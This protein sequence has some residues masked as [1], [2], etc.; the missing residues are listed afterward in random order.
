MGFAWCWDGTEENGPTTTAD[1]T[2]GVHWWGASVGGPDGNRAWGLNSSDRTQTSNRVSMETYLAA[3]EDY[4]DYVDANNIPTTVIFTTG[5]V[6]S[7]SGENGYQQHLKYEAIRDY[8]NADASR[9]LFDYADI[10]SYDD[11]GTLNDTTWSTYTYPIITP[12]NLGA[13]DVGHIGEA[14]RMRLAKAQWWLLARIAGWEGVNHSYYVSTWG[15]DSNSGADTANSWATWQKAFS[16]AQAGD[17]VFF[18]GGVWY[19]Q[20]YYQGNTVSIIVP[21]EIT[22]V[23]TGTTYGNDGTREN[24]ICF[25]NYPG[26]VPILDCSQVDTSGHKYNNALEVYCADWIKFRGLTIRNVYQTKYWDE[27]NPQDT[28]AKVASGFSLYVCSN[29]TLDQMTVHDIGGRAFS[30]SSTVGYFDI[31]SDTCYYL[32]CDAYNCYDPLSSV[33]GNASDGWKTNTEMPDT[34]YQRKAYYL[35]QNCRSW[36]CSDDG[37]DPSGSNQTVFDNCWSFS[38]GFGGVVDGNG[39]KSGGVDGER[40]VNII[41]RV[42]KNNIAAFNYGIGFYDLEYPNYRRNNARYYNNI[43]WHNGSGIQI[44]NNAAYPESLSE[45]YNNA[46]IGSNGR[47]A[48]GRPQNVVTRSFYTESHNTW[49]YAD[50]SVVGSL[51]FWVPA[52]DVAGTDADYTVT[53]SVT[54]INQLKASRKSD[55]SLPDITAFRLATGSDLIGAG[56]DVG[57]SATPDIGID[58]SYLDSLNPPVIRKAATVNGKFAKSIRGNLL[59][60]NQ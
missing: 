20:D 15:N 53:D 27:N 3:T 14:G 23:Y 31:E 2:L 9:I 60:F 33:P 25:F 10:L 50:S 21:K 35:Y 26:E 59:I 38:N 29:I 57:M 8:V 42:V 28:A 45:Y 41:T 7:H 32:N 18:R 4:I 49:D 55:G 16:T 44:S 37:F 34:S 52:S 40:P 13:A 11:N 24:P 30:I 19:P 54:I 36:N 56:T 39:F 46:I 48:G 47:D 6:D 22:G 1:P 51:F 17:T 5:P 43:S 58:W 12:T